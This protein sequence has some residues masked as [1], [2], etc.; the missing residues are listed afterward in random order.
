[1]A[2]YEFFCESCQKHFEQLTSATD[3]EQGRCPKCQGNKTRRL[4]SRFAVGGRGDLRESTFHGC[5]DHD[6]ASA[7]HNHRVSHGH[8][9]DED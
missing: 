8:D 5:H 9:H 4:I 3:P 6:L 7:D 2:L 1:M